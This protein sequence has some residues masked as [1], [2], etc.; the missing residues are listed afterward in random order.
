MIQQSGK[1]TA[2]VEI[3]KGRVPALH[4]NLRGQLA[5]HAVQIIHVGALDQNSVEVQVLTGT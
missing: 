5:P 3:L 2:P 1:I 4:E